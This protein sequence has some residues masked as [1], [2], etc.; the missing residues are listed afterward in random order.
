MLTFLAIVVVGGALIATLLIAVDQLIELL[1]TYREELAGSQVSIQ[2]AQM[3]LGFAQGIASAS[4]E[5]VEPGK[6]MDL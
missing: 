6:E 5:V 2:D 1:P 3:G 4:A